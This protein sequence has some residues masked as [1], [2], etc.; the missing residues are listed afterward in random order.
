V[1][2]WFSIEVIDGHHHAASQWADA[3]GDGLVWAAQAHG[4]TDWD[5]H[6]HTWGVVLE[7]ELADEAAWESYLADPSVRAALDAVP[8]PVAGV[9]TYR[10][11][12]G[13][14]GA[15]DPRKPRPLAGAGA[16]AL[17]VPVDDDWWGELDTTELT[18]RRVLVT[19]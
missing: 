2:E 13:S 9:I 16:A 4:A 7:I 1:P 8:D 11:R 14:A 6:R 17:P 12:G 19:R 3:H 15:R 18:D 5:W 10:G